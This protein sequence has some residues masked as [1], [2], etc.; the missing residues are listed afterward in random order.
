MATPM[1]STDRRVLA[2]LGDRLA[3]QRL[4]RNLTQDQLAREAGVSKRTVVRLENG[5]SSQVTNLVR[6]LRA[7]SLLGNL[8]VLVPAPLAS[9]IE[10]LGQTRKPSPALARRQEP[11]SPFQ[12]DVGA[13]KA[14]APEATPWRT[15]A[16]VRMWGRQIGAVSIDGPGTSAS[17]EYT[18]AFARSG[19]EVA[20]L[21]MPLSRQ[22]YTFPDLPRVSFHGLP[23]ML[24]DALPDKFGNAVIDAWLAA[25]GRLPQDIDAV[26]RLCYTGAVGRLEFKPTLGP[27]SRK[28][29]PVKVD[30]LVEL[31]AEVLR[32]RRSLHAS[33]ADTGRQHALRQ[34]L[35]VGASAG[36]A[37]K[38]LSPGIR[39]RTKSG[40]AR[41]RRR[42]GSSTGC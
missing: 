8:D 22:I 17:F 34:I 41:S 16:E 31:A 3:R 20:P 5:Q 13:M 25:G 38:R 1:E 9:P 23:G 15:V 14:D 27:R 32:S 10:D 30:A 2:E 6:I 28:S 11:P 7:L 42:R 24:A 21:M 12:L 39:A 35:L 19:I 40:P 37:P 4:N 29:T 36:L 18:D 26:E 33:F